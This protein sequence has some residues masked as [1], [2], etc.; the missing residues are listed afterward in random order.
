M[1]QGRVLAEREQQ[2]E[3]PRVRKQGGVFRG[4]KEGWQGSV[5]MYPRRRRRLPIKQAGPVAQGLVG[6]GKGFGFGEF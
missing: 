1:Q 4:Q 6:C 3:R 5:I 2:V